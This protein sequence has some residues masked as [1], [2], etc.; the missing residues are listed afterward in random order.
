MRKSLARTDLDVRVVMD[1]FI[2]TML[3][4]IDTIAIAKVVEQIERMKAMT[5]RQVAGYNDAYLIQRQTIAQ[6]HIKAYRWI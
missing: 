4:V 5:A 3:M 1:V 2:A 6:Q